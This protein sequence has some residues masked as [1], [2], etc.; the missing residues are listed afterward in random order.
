MNK[1]F[2]SMLIAALISLMT[3]A[4]SGEDMQS[5]SELYKD[6]GGKPGLVKVVDDFMIGLLAEPK[7]K[8]SFVN[9]DQKHI[10]EMLVDQFCE[11]L[12]LLREQLTLM[13]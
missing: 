12:D 10:K 8:P 7:T 6:F 4:A 9:A 1:T 5:Q 3:G 13:F 11:L 2:K